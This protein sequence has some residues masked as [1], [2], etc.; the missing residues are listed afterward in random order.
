MSNNQEEDFLS[1]EEGEET[2][3]YFFLKDFQHY[4]THPKWGR[5]LQKETGFPI[6]HYQQAAKAFALPSAYNPT[7]LMT[8]LSGEVGE[9]ASLL[10]KSVR[11]GY[12][13]D[14]NKMCKELGDVLWFVALLADYYGL[15]LSQL[16]NTNL[17]KLTGRLQRNTLQGSGDD[18]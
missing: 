4:S 9:A 8:G 11:D 10:A 16:A 3:F 14:V 7:Y 13:V 2:A 12:P 5:I 15:S 17:E 1:G 6:N 18:R